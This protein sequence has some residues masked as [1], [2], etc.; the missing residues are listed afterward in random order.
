LYYHLTNPHAVTAD[1]IA[2]LQPSDHLA[3]IDF[4]PNRRLTR[5]SSGEGAPENRTGHGIE[6]D[7]VIAELIALSFLL[8]ARYDDY[9]AANYY[10]IFIRTES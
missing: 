4:E 5:I 8:D 6:P 10:L 2:I 1:L 7:A 3:I 9:S